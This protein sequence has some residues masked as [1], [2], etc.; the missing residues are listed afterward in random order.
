MADPPNGNGHTIENILGLDDELP[1]LGS[2]G[3]EIG[4]WLP[5]LTLL[6]G[7]L[8]QYGESKIDWLL[9]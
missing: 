6:L 4:Y 8:R 1:R 5:Y 9:I 3:H 7:I 2:T